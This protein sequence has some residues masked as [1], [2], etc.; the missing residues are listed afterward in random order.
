[1]LGKA[2]ISWCPKKKSVVALF[3]CEEEYIIA[4]MS[5]CNSVMNMELMTLLVANQLV[6]NLAKR[7]I[8][9]WKEQTH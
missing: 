5:S 9:Y 7:P 2:L 4:G 1:M 3:S 6:I 8:A